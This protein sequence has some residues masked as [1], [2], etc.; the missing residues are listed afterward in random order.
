M[1]RFVRYVMRRLVASR[2][3]DGVKKAQSKQL[4]EAQLVGSHRPDGV[5]F[6]VIE[7]SDV[8]RLVASRRLDGVDKRRS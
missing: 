7:T 6:I 2:R 1:L 5:T 4:P 8:R 3:P